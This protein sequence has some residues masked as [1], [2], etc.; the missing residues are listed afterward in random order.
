MQ[1]CQLKLVETV[2]TVFQKK[3]LA[4]LVCAFLLAAGVASSAVEDA[5]LRGGVT[6]AK[7][8]STPVQQ[9]DIFHGQQKMIS[10]HERA[11]H[12][13][14][15]S[16][17]LSGGENKHLAVAGGGQGSYFISYKYA[18]SDCTGPGAKLTFCHIFV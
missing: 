9:L 12:T 7:S 4:D 11:I 6:M 1:Q 8:S 2:L 15:S 10:A 5:S 17:K 3:M 18:N 14:V 16:T 13:A